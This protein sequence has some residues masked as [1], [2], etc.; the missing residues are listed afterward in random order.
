MKS[1]I[2]TNLL[3][4]ITHWGK[5]GFLQFLVQFLRVVSIPLSLTCRLSVLTPFTFTTT[6]MILC[7]GSGGPKRDVTYQLYRFQA[8]QSSGLLFIIV[9]QWPCTTIILG[10]LFLTR[11]K[12]SYSNNTEICIPSWKNTAP[13]DLYQS[14]G[15]FLVQRVG[16]LIPL[17]L[18]P[19]VF[20]IA[21]K[22]PNPWS[23]PLVD[24]PT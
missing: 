3:I 19:N 1:L 13:V 18:L 22:S 2:L 9:P 15:L 23:N 20:N 8:L 24:S 11:M 16:S 12:F 21:R 14:I 17:S 4:I 7:Y 5:S 6:R 10:S